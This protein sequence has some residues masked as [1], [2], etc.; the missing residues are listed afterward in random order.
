[1]MLERV[2]GLV[3]ISSAVVGFAS[4]ILYLK[5]RGEE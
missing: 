2:L 1:M 3:L 5:R 4:M